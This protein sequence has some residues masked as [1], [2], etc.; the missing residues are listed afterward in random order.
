MI[1]K[2]EMVKNRSNTS[3]Y[4]ILRGRT[5]ELV[6]DSEFESES[7]TWIYVKKVEF[8]LSLLVLS[9]SLVLSRSLSFSL[10]LSRS[11]SFSRSRALALPL[12]TSRSVTLTLLSKSHLGLTEWNQTRTLM[13]DVTEGMVVEDMVEEVTF[14]FSRSLVLSFSR[15]L[16]LSIPL[17]LSLS[18]TLSLSLSLSLSLLSIYG[19]SLVVALSLSPSPS[20]LPFPS[21]CPHIPSRRVTFSELGVSVVG[22]SSRCSFLDTTKFKLP[23]THKLPDTGTSKESTVITSL[24]R[25]YLPLTT[26]ATLHLCGVRHR[27]R[28]PS[29]CTVDQVWH[30][31]VVCEG[32]F[33]GFFS[34]R[35]PPGGGYR[36]VPPC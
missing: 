31:L 13:E 8:S 30:S 36:S 4:C 1:N 19:M 27:K 10:V 15:S 17:S 33:S 28:L 7:E 6:S 16:S 11:L 34:P 9:F 18:F 14:S 21:V 12:I 26:V 22:G 24:R 35:V 3:T 2:E 5:F 25:M 23:W 20:W 32:S 29:C